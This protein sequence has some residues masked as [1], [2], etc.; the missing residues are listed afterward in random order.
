MSETVTTAYEAAPERG[1]SAYDKLLF[2]AELVHANGANVEVD[3]EGDPETASALIVKGSCGISARVFIDDRAGEKVL[4]AINDVAARS[5][6]ARDAARAKR[7]R[8]VKRQLKVC[9]A[10]FA[11]EAAP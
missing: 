5:L 11:N 8:S 1:F 10:V 2:P 7:L 4:Y 3:F 9:G 6:A